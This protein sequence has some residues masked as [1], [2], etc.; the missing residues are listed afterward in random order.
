VHVD[1]GMDRIRFVRPRNRW[2]PELQGGGRY[3]GR[4]CFWVECDRELQSEVTLTILFPSPTKIIT[5]LQ[6]LV[7]GTG[8][9]RSRRFVA[10]RA[11]RQFLGRTADLRDHMSQVGVFDR[12]DDTI[13]E[14]IRTLINKP[15]PTGDS[16]LQRQSW[17]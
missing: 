9:D 5:T 11:V 13:D 16:V 17:E 15:V 14:Q 4:M 8:L 6:G 1:K 2:V 3:F 7:L 12:D 10:S